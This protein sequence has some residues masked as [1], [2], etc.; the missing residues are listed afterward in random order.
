L[1]KAQQLAADDW[2]DALADRL[3]AYLQGSGPRAGRITA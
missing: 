3:A 2:R 1:Q